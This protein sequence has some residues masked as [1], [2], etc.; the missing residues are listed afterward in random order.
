[1]SPVYLK[2]F[3]R[4][5]TK[6]APNQ[7]LR[8][9]L[10]HYPPKVTADASPGFPGIRIGQADLILDSAVHTAIQRASIVPNDGTCRVEVR[11]NGIVNTVWRPRTDRV[12]RAITGGD[13]ISHR[14]GD[15]GVHQGG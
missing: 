10:S 13:P 4:V 3:F 7:L 14:A 1:M 9:L 12:V 5:A 15:A 2:A 6:E 11:H 8:H